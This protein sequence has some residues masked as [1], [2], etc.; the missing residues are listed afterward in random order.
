MDRA[1]RIA[2]LVTLAALLFIAAM[3]VCESVRLETNRAGSG[4]QRTVMSYEKAEAIALG[5]VKAREGWSG[6][7]DTTFTVG[8]LWH[9]AVRRRPGSTS[10]W[11]SVII[12]RDGSLLGYAAFTNRAP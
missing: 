3:L 4:P 12:K 9:V 1:D 11:R 2:I 7:A 6:I 10:D 8:S 5:E